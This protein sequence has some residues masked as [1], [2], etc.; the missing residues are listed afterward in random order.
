MPTIVTDRLNYFRYKNLKLFI[1]LNH[2]PLRGKTPQSF[3]PR[4]PQPQHKVRSPNAEKP[5]PSIESGQYSRQTDRA[6]IAERFPILSPDAQS[7]L[8]TP[9]IPKSPT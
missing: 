2:C 7:Q 3:I 9:A 4:P 5:T 8:M 1:S 6:L